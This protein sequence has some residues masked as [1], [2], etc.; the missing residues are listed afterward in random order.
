MNVIESY[1]KAPVMRPVL[2]RWRA[3]KADQRVNMLIWWVAVLEYIRREAVRAPVASVLSILIKVS[4]WYLPRNKLHNYTC[5]VWPLK[6]YFFVDFYHRP[7]NYLQV[8][9]QF[10]IKS[11]L[12]SKI[13]QPIVSIYLL[14]PSCTV[15]SLENNSYLT[16]CN[17]ISE[18]LR[19]L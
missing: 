3:I 6:Y 17:F 13:I 4:S 7:R 15:K 11:K 1:H 10:N 2:T 8:F 16:L 18:N 14:G 12:W 19:D 9:Q 5:F